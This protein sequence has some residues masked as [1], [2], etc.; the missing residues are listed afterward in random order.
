MEALE[1]PGRSRIEL[2]EEQGKDKEL[3]IIRNFLQGLI[4]LEETKDRLIAEYSLR[5]EE[6]TEEENSEEDKKRRVG[7]MVGRTNLIQGIVCYEKRPILPRSLRKVILDCAHM[8]HRGRDNTWAIVKDFYWYGMRED[9]DKYVRGCRGCARKKNPIS[10]IRRGETAAGN[11]NCNRRVPIRG[12]FTPIEVGQPFEKVGMDI[13]GPLPKTKRG[14]RWALV[15]TDLCTRWAIMIPLRGITSQVVAEALFDNVICQHGVPKELISDRGSYFVSRVAKEIYDML[16][17]TKKSS[18]PYHP[19]TNGSVERLNGTLGT[20]I[21]ILCHEN[22]KNWDELCSIA[23]FAYNTSKHGTTGMTPYSLL[24]GRRARLPIDLVWERN[25]D[26]DTRRRIQGIQDR[27][28]TLRQWTKR[29]QKNTKE[30]Q[31]YHRKL[32]DDKFNTQQAY[33]VGEEVWIYCPYVRSGESKKLTLKWRGPAMITKREGDNY[34]VAFGNCELINP[35]HI[36]RLKPYYAESLWPG[37]QFI[38]PPSWGQAPKLQESEIHAANSVGARNTIRFQEKLSNTR[39][40][41]VNSQNGGARNTTSLQNEGDQAQV[42][43]I[44]DEDKE[45]NKRHTEQVEKVKPEERQETL[46]LQRPRRYCKSRY[47]SR[48]IQ[49][50]D[51]LT[52]RQ[53]QCMVCGREIEKNE[54][55]YECSICAKVYH[56]QCSLGDTSGES[57]GKSKK[58]CEECIILEKP[59]TLNSTLALVTKE[60]E[61]EP[62]WKLGKDHINYIFSVWWEQPDWD[63]FAIPTEDTLALRFFNKNYSALDRDWESN[64][65]KEEVKLVHPPTHLWPRIWNKLS[66]ENVKNIILF[67]PLKKEEVIGT[68]EGIEVKPR[69]MKKELEGILI[70]PRTPILLILTKE[71]II[72][73][74][75]QIATTTRNTLITWWKSDEEKSHSTNQ[76]LRKTK[77]LKEGKH[78]DKRIYVWACNS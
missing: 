55:I 15:I 46:G 30:R 26:N 2:Q 45:V 44:S 31:E 7:I 69:A 43:E 48:R 22:Q 38:S 32:F 53:K 58:I 29:N 12:K 65:E 24:Y 63:L 35:V 74:D 21:A 66:T 28:T 4:S 14:N 70:S 49:D 16:G 23:T 1:L 39:K 50:Q 47:A 54:E 61:N 51:I 56:K 8:G 27:I 77:F 59:G 42:W 64:M 25:L 9:V 75:N 78:K 13:M 11:N 6:E 67:I 40:D 57:N 76:Q 19:E 41:T 10:K 17:L 36:T 34:K 5:E 73:K 71:A 18:A 62:R 68:E 60:I 20:S 37:K 33:E 3:L 72:S 52:T